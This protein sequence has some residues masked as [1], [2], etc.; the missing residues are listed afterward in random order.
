[1]GREKPGYIQV[2]INQSIKRTGISA[3]WRQKAD[4]FGYFEFYC[5]ESKNFLK[6]S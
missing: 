2:G 4:I 1:M 6:A 5:V 3:P